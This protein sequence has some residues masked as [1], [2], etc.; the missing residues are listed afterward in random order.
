[1]MKFFPEDKYEVRYYQNGEEYFPAMFLVL[2]REMIQLYQKY[3]EVVCFDLTYNLVDKKSKRG[4]SWGLGNFV[5]IGQ[6]HEILVFGFC[7]MCT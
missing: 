6:N 4:H 5:G 2:S 1:M 7:L 3:G